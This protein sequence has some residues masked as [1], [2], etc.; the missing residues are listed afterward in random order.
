M[1]QGPA[2]NPSSKVGR[3]R[4]LAAT[5]RR[6]HLHSYSLTHLLK[7]SQ[8]S[9][10]PCL[11]RLQVHPVVSLIHLALVQLAAALASS[12]RSCPRRRQSDAAVLQ[13][14]RQGLLEGGKAVCQ[15]AGP[16]C[17]AWCRRGCLGAGGAQAAAEGQE[18]LC[19]RRVLWQCLHILHQPP[20]Q[21]L[22]QLQLVGIGALCCA[23]CGCLL[24]QVS[25]SRGPEQVRFGA[26]A[27][28][29]TCRRCGGRV[30]GRHRAATLAFEQ[31]GHAV[32]ACLHNLVTC[33]CDGRLGEQ[34]SAGWGGKVPSRFA[35]A[36]TLRMC[37]CGSSRRFRTSCT[38]A[39]IARRLL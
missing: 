26:C 14:R 34:G 16:G 36:V 8:P 2:P 35:P 38:R 31:E 1:Q 39:D 4:R 24:C 37:S 17:A 18:A 19:R 5:H 25:P 21:R 12:A 3:Y 9:P 10:Q 29:G 6:A 32:A 15:D 20:P 22:R 23:C 13:R 30:C 27:G 33:G 11:A 28:G 7:G